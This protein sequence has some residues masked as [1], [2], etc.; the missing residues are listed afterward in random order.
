MSRPI[1]AEG[2]WRYSTGRPGRENAPAVAEPPA[3]PTAPTTNRRGIPATAPRNLSTSVILA[4]SSFQRI[5]HPERILEL[6]RTAFVHPIAR[7]LLRPSRPA[8]S[9][10]RA[11]QCP[12][13]QPQ[14]WSS[15]LI[16]RVRQTVIRAWIALFF[17]SN[18]S[19]HCRV[20]AC[21]WPSL[22]TGE[23]ADVKLLAM[24]AD[25]PAVTRLGHFGKITSAG[26]LTRGEGAGSAAA[27]ADHT[28]RARR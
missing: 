18:T 23:S 26:R 21:A 3:A 14:V 10:R 8:S 15:P 25:R 2:T 11:Q 17:R 19:A 1:A 9:P 28:G 5:L 20:F 12:C 27:P 24:S 13:S 7:L 6:G 4:S 16:E 22:Y